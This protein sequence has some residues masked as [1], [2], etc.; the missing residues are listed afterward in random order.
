MVIKMLFVDVDENLLVKGREEA[1]RK[2]RGFLIAW[3]S[4]P[5]PRDTYLEM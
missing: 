5:S 4:A 2:V 3:S 1:R